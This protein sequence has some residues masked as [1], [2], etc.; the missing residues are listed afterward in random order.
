MKTSRELITEL[1]SETCRCGSRKR[2]METLCGSCYYKLP[3]S[4]RRALY[5]RLGQGYEKA[6]ADACNYLDSERE[7]A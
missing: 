6:Y 5:N 1:K 7:L 3:Q 2:P 4:N